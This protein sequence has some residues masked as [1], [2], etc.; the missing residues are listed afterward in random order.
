MTTKLTIKNCEKEN[1]EHMCEH[2]NKK[3]KRYD[4]MKESEFA[5]FVLLK[6]CVPCFIK[7]EN[8]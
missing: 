5:S 3:I 1:L 7:N 8:G 4:D 6:I 2:C